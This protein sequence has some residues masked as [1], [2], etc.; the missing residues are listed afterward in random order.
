MK[1]TKDEIQKIEDVFIQ[2]ENRVRQIEAYIKTNNEQKN[3]LEQITEIELPD[4]VNGYIERM[5]M[6]SNSAVIYNAAIISV[7][8]S[9]ELFLD[10]IL[11]AYLQYLKKNR[12]GYDDLPAKI[13]IK[14][15]AKSAEYLINPGRFLNMGLNMK[16]IISS[17]E[18]TI[19]ENNIEATI[20]D[21]LIMHGGN[22][23]TRQL[24]ALLTEF[25]FKNVTALLK[26]NKGLV[27]FSKDK[28]ITGDVIQAKGFPLLDKIVEERNRVAHGWRVD[29]RLSFYALL[30]TYIPFMK[31]LCKAIKELIVSKI[32]SDAIVKKVISPFQPI[33]HLW[34]KN[35]VVGVN[36]GDFFLKVGEPLFYST[37]D[38]WYYCTVIKGL[39]N[40]RIDRNTIRAKNKDITIQVEERFQNHYQIWGFERKD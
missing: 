33:I 37:G 13:K 18:K 36:C 6:L 34:H 23:N 29:D 16:S 24:T 21:L 22:L 2:N 25:E 11:K 7:Y 5:D 3:F 9:Y 20:D 8:G 17:M 19:N 31:V 27:D 1:N 35:T 12:T 26:K 30:D 39:Q 15:L 32:I 10:E 4:E 28:G 40:D 38:G 14:H